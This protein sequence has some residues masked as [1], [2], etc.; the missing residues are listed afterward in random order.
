MTPHPI[1]QFV[2]SYLTAHL[3]RK[4]NST[5]SGSVKYVCGHVNKNDVVDSVKILLRRRLNISDMSDRTDGVHL[6]HFITKM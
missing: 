5:R 3:T 2:L 1:S 6:K 4:R